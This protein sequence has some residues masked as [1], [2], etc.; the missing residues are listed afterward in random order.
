MKG[1][2]LDN[3]AFQKKV[4]TY[5]SRLKTRFLSLY[6]YVFINPRMYDRMNQF[7][8]VDAYIQ[9]WR[10]MTSVLQLSIKNIFIAT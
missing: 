9:Q 7:I 5:L 10:K 6:N 3:I 2:N 4:K 8:F 1:N